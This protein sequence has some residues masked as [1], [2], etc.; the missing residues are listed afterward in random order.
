VSPL[1]LSL[2]I[3][4]ASALI[5]MP[6]AI[7]LGWV[8]AR[9]TFR[10]KTLLSALVLAPLVLPPVV[11][12]L[13]LLR[14]LGRRGAFGP[15]LEGIGVSVP[16]TTLGAVIAALVVGLPLYVIAARTAFEGVDPRLEEV[17]STLG[18]S[19]L[20]VLTRITLPLAWPGLL[21]GAVL[22]F[23]RA[24]GEFG[25]TAVLAGDV[26][27]ETRTIALAVYAA[28]EAPRGEPD[29]LRLSLLSVGLSVLALVFHELLLARHVRRAGRR[30]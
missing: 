2:V 3:A 6:P 10:G 29:A 21:A 22:A 7:A 24:L 5:G 14:L 17:A 23:A 4:C 13:L 11:T 16:F 8:L 26:P 20:R 15:V 19:P 9:R 18:A 12:G 28:L 30:A 25:A 1:V 27:G